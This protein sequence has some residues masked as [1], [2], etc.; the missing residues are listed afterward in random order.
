MFKLIL[1]LLL[2]GLSSWALAQVATNNL[3]KNEFLEQGASKKVLMFG[4]WHKINGIPTRSAAFFGEYLLPELSKKGFNKIVLEFLPVDFQ[5]ADFQDELEYLAQTNEIDP[6]HTPKLE[7]IFSRIKGGVYAVTLLR[8]A[9]Q[10][11]MQI[12]GCGMSATQWQSIKDKLE[13]KKIDV[14]A[15]DAEAS[16]LV[17]KNILEVLEKKVGEKG[18]TLFFLGFLHI[19]K[20]GPVTAYPQLA[21]KLGKENV[22]TVN[23]INLRLINSMARIPEA[24]PYIQK[25]KKLIDDYLSQ[26][27]WSAK[28]NFP[29]VF[30]AAPND[31]EGDFLYFF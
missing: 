9:Y 12:S 21:K 3:S 19:E 17:Q 8:I 5:T 22:L 20:K 15:A 4:E 10:N 7:K 26:R 1:V 6:T 13:E 28:D 27:D 23:S 2:S 11:K 24:L 30:K 25:Y 14:N 29:V 16:D 18:Q 31:N